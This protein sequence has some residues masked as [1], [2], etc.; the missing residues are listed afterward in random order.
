MYLAYNYHL[1]DM[2]I[3][4]KQNTGASFTKVI[5]RVQITLHSTLASVWLA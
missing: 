3:L 5:L 1:S 2:K 4:I